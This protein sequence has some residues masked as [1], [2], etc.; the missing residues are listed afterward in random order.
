MFLF[1]FEGPTMDEHCT[2]AFYPHE[3]KSQLLLVFVLEKA[4]KALSGGPLF[5]NF[6]GE[7]MPLKSPVG[8]HL[9]YTCLVFV[10]TYQLLQAPLEMF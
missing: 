10:P 6:H 4:G 1:S 2:A 9:W 3:I 5:Q 8:E 7:H